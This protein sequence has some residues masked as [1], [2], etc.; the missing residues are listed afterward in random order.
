MTTVSARL[1]LAMETRLMVKGLS[2]LKDLP[3]VTTNRSAAVASAQTPRIQK[4][5]MTPIALRI[6]SH[7]TFE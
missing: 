1:V 7:C 2:M 6:R 5:P 3:T 4:M